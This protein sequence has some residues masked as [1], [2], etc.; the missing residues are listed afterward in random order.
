MN[1]RSCASRFGR[2]L[3][4]FLWI[5]SLV[6]LSSTA[7]PQATS[8]DISG[9]VVDK[10][11]SVVAN[12]KVVATRND[13]NESFTTSTN[14]SGEFRFGNLPVGTYSV[15]ASKRLQSHNFEGFSGGAEQ[16]RH[17]PHADGDR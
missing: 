6:L 17:R 7:Y 1:Q 10:T 4:Y 9:T 16:N 3:S 8:G 15:T 12:A 14:S 5:T 11:N 13:T 2:I